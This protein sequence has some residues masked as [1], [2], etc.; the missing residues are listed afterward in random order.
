MLQLCVSCLDGY[1]KETTSKITCKSV[2]Y[3]YGTSEKYQVELV[4]Q[5]CLHTIHVL[6]LLFCVNVCAKIVLKFKLHKKL[7]VR[8]LCAFIDG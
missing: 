4:V 3:I 1:M 7:L 8:A 6:V 2:I 5:I